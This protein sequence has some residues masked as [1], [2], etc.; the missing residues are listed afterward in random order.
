[1]TNIT[2]TT[3]TT[4]QRATP[5]K[6]A[7]RTISYVRRYGECSSAMNWGSGGRGDGAVGNSCAKSYA[8]AKLERWVQVHRVIEPGVLP[9]CVA[10]QPS[11]AHPF[12][13]HVA[14]IAAQKVEVKLI[15]FFL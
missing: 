4:T 12:A 13:V 5:P 6:T 14:Q 9:P 8:V 11:V 3:T 15:I 1:M 2:V 7:M 10:V